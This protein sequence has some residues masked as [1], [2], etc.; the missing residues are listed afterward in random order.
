M[1]IEFHTDAS[2]EVYGAVLI[3]KENK[4]PH[5]VSYFS[6]KTTDEESRYHS[7]ELETLAVV[8]RFRHYLRGRKFQVFTDCNAL[9]ALHSKKDL[10]P[11]V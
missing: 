4:V 2:S 6:R 9:K 8:E 10:T 3:Q 1:P 5:V 11:R 7:Y